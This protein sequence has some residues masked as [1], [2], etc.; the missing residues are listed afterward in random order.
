MRVE[1]L[2]ILGVT[3]AT[4]RGKIFHLARNSILR[5]VL[6]SLSR[7]GSDAHFQRA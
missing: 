5:S 1:K 2:A 6:N 7:L 3:A 4:A